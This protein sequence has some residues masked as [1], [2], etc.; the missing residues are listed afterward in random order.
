MG[1]HCTNCDKDTDATTARF[2]GAPGDGRALP[3]EA[4]FVCSD[5]YALAELFHRRALEQAKSL[6]ALVGESIRVAMVEKRF[7]LGELPPQREL[8]K[9]EVFESLLQM[10]QKRDEATERKQSDVDTPP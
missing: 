7:M 2:F 3:H 10:M 4:V 8:T 6:V 9:R 1:L 5:C